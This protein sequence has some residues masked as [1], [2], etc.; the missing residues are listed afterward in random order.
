MPYIRHKMCIQSKVNYYGWLRIGCTG[1]DQQ[2]LRFN[3]RCTDVPSQH[4]YF[5]ASD[6]CWTDFEKNL[7]GN[8]CHQE[9]NWL[10]FG[11]NCTRDKGTG[12]D[13][14]FESTSNRCCQVAN[15]FTNFVV[16]AARC[17]RRAGESITHM[18]R[19]RPRTVF[20]SVCDY[21]LQVSPRFFLHCLR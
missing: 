11:R 21:Q 8:Q 17:V 5:F 4:L 7:E 14:K 1:T 16:H 12:C 2:Q 9:L 18:Q 13:R 15:N 6:E 19:G 20:S 10:H 3:A